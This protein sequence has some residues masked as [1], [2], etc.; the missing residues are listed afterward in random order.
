MT[1]TRV[2]AGIHSFDAVPPVADFLLALSTITNSPLIQSL[3][4]Q[5]DMIDDT[6]I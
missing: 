4:T 6:Y 1:E 5:H 3:N 2:G